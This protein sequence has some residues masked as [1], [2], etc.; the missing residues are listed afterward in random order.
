MADRKT[1][2]A[3]A[4]AAGWEP[5]YYWVKMDGPGWWEIG[6]WDGQK[7]EMRGASITRRDSDFAEVL[8]S[9]LAAP[10]SPLRDGEPGW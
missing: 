8:P 5:G 10:D 2:A 7:W 3:Q 6:H 1:A 4:D 9:R